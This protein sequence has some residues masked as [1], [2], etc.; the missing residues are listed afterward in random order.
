MSA[1]RFPRVNSRS[2]GGVTNQNV[3]VA[4]REEVSPGIQLLRSLM[5][6]IVENRYAAQSC[7][8]RLIVLGR[9]RNDVRSLHTILIHT[10]AALRPLSWQKYFL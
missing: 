10:V 6:W 7:D 1:G 3:E 2:P 4:S 8:D 9:L 5:S